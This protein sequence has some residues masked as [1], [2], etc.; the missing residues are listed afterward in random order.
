MKTGMRRNARGLTLLELLVALSIG[1]F[2]VGGVISLFLAAKR[3]YTETDQAARTSENGRFALITLGRDIRQAG[4]F[5]AAGI[6]NTGLDPDLGAVTGDCN[7][8][9]ASFDFANY[10]T[11]VRA[12]AA[13]A[14][15]GCIT[16]AVPES[17]V[18]VIK[19]VRG[20]Q[21]T[22]AQVTAAPNAQ[23]AFVLSNIDRGVVFRGGDGTRPSADAGG[24]VPDGQFWRY[25]TYVYY[26]RQGAVPSL[27]R[28]SLGVRSGALSMAA[29]NL[30][31]GVE[32]MRVL[33]GED[34]NGDG[35]VDRL[36]QADAVADWTR[37][38][39]IQPNLLVRSAQAE[40]G[41]IDDRTYNLPGLAVTPGGAFRRTVLAETISLRNTLFIVR[42]GA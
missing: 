23:A 37:V 3:S 10:F 19:N 30:A 9:A 38:L 42:G 11:V 16:D 18:I 4:F 17:D 34:T 5:G 20:E 12:S 25:Q 1:I 8:P 36:V 39:S 2:L 28:L 27:A 35:N 26:V 22:L 21:L 15:L 13:G 6:P 7:A 31:E 29:E 33:A 41:L 14:A 24:E 40:A 32:Q